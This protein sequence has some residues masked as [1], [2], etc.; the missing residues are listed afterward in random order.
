MN[1]VTARTMQQRLAYARVYVEIEASIDV[2][3]SIDVEM[4]SGKIIHVP[5]QVS[6]MPLRCSKCKIFGHADRNYP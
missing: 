3:G 2:S 4:K 1:N 5:V 6:W